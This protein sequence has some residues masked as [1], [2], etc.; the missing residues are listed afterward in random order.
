MW[1]KQVTLFQLPDSF[2]R[3][4][5]ELAQKLEPLAFSPCLPS[6]PSSQGWVSPVHEENAPLVQTINGYTMLCLQ[7]EEKILP[8]SYVN[9]EL[10][11]KLKEIETQQGRKVRQKE[12][13]AMKDELVATLLPRAFT[14]LTRVYGYLDPENNGL[15]LGTNNQ[16]RLDQFRTYFTRSLNEET[17]PLNIKKLGPTLTLW[18]KTQ[19]YSSNFALEKACLLQDPNQENR[20][21]RCQHQDLLAPSLQGFI[22]D[23][24]QVKQL[25]LSWQDRIQFVLADDF[26][27]S[28]LKYQ[29]ELISEAKDLEAETLQQKFIADFLIMSG[30]L[31]AL[32]KD[33]RAA[34]RL[35]QE[36]TGV[37]GQ[38]KIVPMAKVG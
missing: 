9:Q 36:E 37:E 1:F 23:G 38:G 35:E 34:L 16:K 3:K 22:K 8:M 26:S 32:L 31:S 12:K 17:H 7:I 21:I 25:A 18:L 13:F 2:R 19:N 6:L 15:V 28:G 24:C 10:L 11:K 27:L 30:T 33:L 5:Q 20:L 4:T 29:E 14:K